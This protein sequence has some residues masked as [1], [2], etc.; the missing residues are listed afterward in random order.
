MQRK[1]DELGAKIIEAE[2]K[3]KALE[4]SR[5]TL[6]NINISTKVKLSNK[7]VSKGDLAQKNAIE[8]QV[9]AAS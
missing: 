2:K 8:E 5:V 3:L 7:G 6:E 4:N 9:N 1:G